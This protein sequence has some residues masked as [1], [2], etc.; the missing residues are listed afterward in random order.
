MAAM[1]GQLYGLSNPAKS[2]PSRGGGRVLLMAL[3]IVLVAQCFR[4]DRIIDGILLQSSL[5][6]GALDTKTR[7]LIALA[8][9]V[10]TRCGSC[11]PPTPP[12]LH[13]GCH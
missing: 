7:E 9:A 6:G 12:Q 8:V 13:G 1:G 4:V 5:A 2:P 11:L 3:K 10:T